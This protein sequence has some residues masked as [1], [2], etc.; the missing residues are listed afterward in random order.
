MRIGSERNITSRHAGFRGGFY[1]RA[2]GAVAVA[3][4]TLVCLIF[5]VA[6]LGRL[7]ARPL[8]EPA[9]NPAA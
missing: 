1:A 9:G 6:V 2:F 5:V 4:H 7:I 8:M 3:R